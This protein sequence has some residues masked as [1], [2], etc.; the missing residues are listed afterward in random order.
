MNLAG[1]ETLIDA[2]KASFAAALRVPDGVG[3]PVALLWTDADGQWKPLI[4]LLQSNAK[5]IVSARFL[6]TGR[7]SRPGHL[8]EM[9][10]R[11][12]IA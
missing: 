1:T 5:S 7:T 9:H 12:D 3:A 6:R 2:M 8:A 11:Q 10:R 4:P